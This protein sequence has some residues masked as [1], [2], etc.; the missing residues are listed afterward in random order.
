MPAEPSEGRYS[1]EHVDAVDDT[2]VILPSI[3]LLGS[4]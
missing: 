4:C 3:K 1:A 2:D